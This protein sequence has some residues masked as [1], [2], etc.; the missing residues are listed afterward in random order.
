[1]A[2]IV[3]SMV[4]QDFHDDLDLEV[5]IPSVSRGKSSDLIN[6][7]TFLRQCVGSK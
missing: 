4:S 1:M 3:S 5:K 6:N 7:A 2:R